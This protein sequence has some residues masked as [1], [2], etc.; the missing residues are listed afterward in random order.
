M[1]QIPG[2]Q[3]FGAR[4]EPRHAAGTAQSWHGDRERRS[5]LLQRWAT[6]SAQHACFDG[7]DRKSLKEGHAWSQSAVEMGDEMI[8]TGMAVLA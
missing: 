3:E 2:K 8:G 1:S 7:I 6:I 4:L 5:D